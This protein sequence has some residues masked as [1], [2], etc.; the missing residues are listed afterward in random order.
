MLRLA[1]GVLFLGLAFNCGAASS[2]N[3][4]V[5]GLIKPSAGDE[6]VVPVYYR[7][8][9]YRRTARYAVPRYRHARRCRGDS[10]Q[11]ITYDGDFMCVPSNRVNT[12][13]F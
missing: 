13:M 3:A 2:A 10:I 8:V 12:H 9:Y 7:R 4:A 11:T 6:A 5:A 1:F